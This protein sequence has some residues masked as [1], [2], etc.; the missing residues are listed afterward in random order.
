MR[1]TS[2]GGSRGIG[3]VAV[4]ADAELLEALLHLGG[5]LVVIRPLGD[6]NGADVQ[7]AL[8]ELVDLTQNLVV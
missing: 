8:A 2:R 5:R 6:D 3:E 4:D 1:S 7:A